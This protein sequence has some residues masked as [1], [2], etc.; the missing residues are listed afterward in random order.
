MTRRGCDL[1]PGDTETARSPFPGAVRPGRGSTSVRPVGTAALPSAHHAGLVPRPPASPRLLPQQSFSCSTACSFNKIVSTAVST[2][3]Y[4]A[5]QKQKSHFPENFHGIWM[6]EGKKQSTP[7]PAQEEDAP[8]GLP[9]RQAGNTARSPQQAIAA[10]KDEAALAEPRP[11]IC[12]CCLSA[13][14]ST[15]NSVS[16]R[17]CRAGQNQPQTPSLCCL[18]SAGITVLYSTAFQSMPKFH[19]WQIC[20]TS[21]LPLSWGTQAFPASPQA[22]CITRE[23]NG[24]PLLLLLAFLNISEQL[25]LAAVFR[26]PF[27]S[28]VCCPAVVRKGRSFYALLEKQGRPA[29]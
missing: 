19:L 2:S 4:V 15:P 13:Q 12:C 7:R 10:S 5:D 14:E 25:P 29:P 17:V 28:Q 24:L 20:S 11:P 21:T 9:G 22:G 23:Q 1:R 26:T 6:Q 8:E 27:S 3:A 18:T 16:L